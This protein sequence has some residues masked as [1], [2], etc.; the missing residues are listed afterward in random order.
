MKQPLTEKTRSVRSLVAGVGLAGFGLLNGSAGF[1][2]S[3][4]IAQT[5]TPPLEIA[6]VEADWK[7]IECPPAFSPGVPRP[8]DPNWG[9]NLNCWDIVRTGFI[10]VNNPRAEC[11]HNVEEINLATHRPPTRRY[12]LTDEMRE[13]GHFAC[14]NNVNPDCG[15]PVKYGVLYGAEYLSDLPDRTDPLWRQLGVEPPPRMNPRTPP[16]LW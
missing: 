6:Q 9:Y 8:F 15:N 1:L 11:G 4:A 7:E 14:V 13:R 16:G 5:P 10:C 3:P 12:T 2:A